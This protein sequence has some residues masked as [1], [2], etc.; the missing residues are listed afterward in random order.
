MENDQPLPEQV[1]L[2]DP[3]SDTVRRERRGLLA[4][5][6]IAIAVV[7]GH[8]VPAKLVMADIELSLDNQQFLLWLLTLVVVYFL[9]AF[10]LYA[11]SEIGLFGFAWRATRDPK[12]VADAMF[13]KMQTG[14]WPKDP[15]DREQLVRDLTRAYWLNTIN[16][17]GPSWR[18][19]LATLAFAMRVLI[20][21][22]VPIAVGIYAVVLLYNAKPTLPPLPSYPVWTFPDLLGHR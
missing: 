6:L 22:V 5:S 10:P 7:K 4:V 17:G 8:L 1:L 19:P 13:D 15:E 16:A 20:D 9:I 14:S 11:F 21:I 18:R 2:K 12:V 3:L